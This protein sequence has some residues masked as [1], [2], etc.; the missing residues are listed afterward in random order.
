M[1]RSKLIPSYT[2]DPGILLLSAIAVLLVASF[3]CGC[4]Q[5]FTVLLRDIRSLFPKP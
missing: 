2:Q 1:T 4:R 3:L 5:R